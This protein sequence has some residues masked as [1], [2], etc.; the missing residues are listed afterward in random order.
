MSHPMVNR[1]AYTPIFTF[2]SSV[3]PAMPAARLIFIKAVVEAFCSG[4]EK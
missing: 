4:G 1:F 3:G 2:T